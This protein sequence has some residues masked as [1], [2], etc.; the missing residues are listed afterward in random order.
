MGKN[1]TRLFIS[2]SRQDEE[3]VRK[4]ATD[5]DQLGAEVWIDLDDI[6]AGMKW[7]TAIAQGLKEAEIM[8]VVISPTSMTSRNVEDEWQYF[9]D[10][11]KPLMPVLWLPAEVHFQLS[12]IEF[13]DFH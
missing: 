6:P 8:I 11:D 3:F 12:R 5:L 1:M 2:Y 7:S 10:H 9:R 4:L 13:I